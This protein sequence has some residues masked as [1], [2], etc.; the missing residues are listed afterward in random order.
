[1]A[2]YLEVEGPDG[3]VVEFPKGTDRATMAAAMKS[4]YDAQKSAEPG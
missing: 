1:M 3:K 2:D 4:Y